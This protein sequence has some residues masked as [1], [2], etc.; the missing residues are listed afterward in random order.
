MDRYTE[1]VS[2]AN[3]ANLALANHN[4]QDALEAYASALKIS[5]ELERSRLVAALFNRMGSVLQ[6]KGEIQDA[7]IAYESALR[8]LE[9]D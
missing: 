4:D 6:V 5:R 2:F 9:R 7:A 8:A 3:Q 1:V